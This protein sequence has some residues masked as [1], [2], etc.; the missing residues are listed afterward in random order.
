[1]NSQLDQ[2]DATIRA[3]SRRT[4]V[5][6]AAWST[7]AVTIVVATPNIAAA[8]PGAA[9]QGSATGT[10]T[11]TDKTATLASKLKND[12]T[13]AM[14]GLTV[15]ISGAVVP[16]SV[17]NGLVAGWTRG[18]GSSYTYAGSLSSLSTADFEPARIDLASNGQSE[19]VVLTFTAGT[20]SVTV[21]TLT[22]AFTS[23]NQVRTG[24]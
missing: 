3:A 2:V 21:D 19:T 8:T 5:R 18:S 6:G 1:M 11:R 10:S 4:V 23:K 24:T 7:A 13:Q 9:P 16:S 22:F 17:N 15:T 14:T 12:G 20:P